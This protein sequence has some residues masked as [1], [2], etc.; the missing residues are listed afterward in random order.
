MALRLLSKKIPIDLFVASPAR[1]AKNTA[2]LFI[3]TYHRN[4]EEIRLIPSLYHAAV[5]TFYEVIAGL[6]N[7]FECPALFSHNPGITE[8]VN[9][10]TQVRVDNMPTCGV[11]GVR[12]EIDDWGQFYEAKKEFWFFDYPKAGS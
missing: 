9:T 8:F 5:Q 10:L 3:K 4:K 7:S 6:E 12:A 11:F 2:E 1:R